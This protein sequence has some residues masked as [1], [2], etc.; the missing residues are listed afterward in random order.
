MIRRQPAIEDLR[1]YVQRQMDLWPG[2]A[3]VIRALFAAFAAFAAF[4][5][6]LPP[7]KWI[8]GRLDAKEHR[9]GRHF[10]LVNREIVEVDR[11]TFDTLTEGEALK[12][13]STRSN[14]AISIDRLVP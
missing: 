14:R 2:M 8:E 9:F 6:P 11:F 7:Y 10:L 13:R 1:P 5:D 12:V 4:V 3:Q